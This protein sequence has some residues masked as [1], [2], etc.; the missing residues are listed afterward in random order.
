MPSDAPTCEPT[1]VEAFLGVDHSLSGRKWITREVDE[2]DIATI[3]RQ[4]DVPEALARVIAGRGIDIELAERYLNPR[5]RDEFPDPSDFADMD[6]AAGLIW[7]ALDAGRT[8]AVFADYDV[9]GATS[10]AQL[11]RWMR[12]VGHDLDLYVPDRVAEGYGPSADAFAVLKE[13][14][15]EIVITVDCGA[16]AASALTAAQEMGL[17][18]I[19]VDHHLMD[20]D[21][22]PTA[23][24]VN[25]NRDDDR[26]GCGHMAAA[27]VTFILL[28]A[29]NR[30][31]RRRGRFSDRPE[32]DL[33]ALS[34]LAA[35]GTICD[36]VALTGINR[37]IV[38]QGLKRMSGTSH[39]GLQALADVAGVDGPATPYHAG[40]LLGP[41][42]NAGGRVGRA[43]LGARLLSTEDQ[44]EATKIASQLDRFNTERRDI[45]RDVL[46]AALAQLGGQDEDRGVLIAAGEDWHP[47]VIGIA[48]GRIKDK[49]GKP[50]IVI[51]IDR[52]SQPAVGKGSG[53]SVPGVNLGAAISAAREAGLLSSGGGHAMAG[54]LTV[55]PD[56]ITELTAFLD[57]R[58]AA[59]LAQASDA[60]AM[61]LDGLLTPSS[62][63]IGLADLLSRAGPFG[64]GNAEPRFALANLRVSFAK[65]VGT[66]HVRYTL[67][68]RDGTSISGIAFRCA[69]QPIGQSL[70]AA[71]GQEWHVAGR[72]K[73]DEWQGR[74]RVQ[75]QLEDM[76]AV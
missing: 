75:L 35:L 11:I 13:R 49:F 40:F 4:Q 25:P 24:L 2:R 46:D 50:S 30:E 45:E 47:G 57:D 23:A 7:D 14:G 44:A 27:G 52:S 68:D 15:A 29:L 21:I 5:L 18:V 72:L 53:R 76:A 43:D 55:D 58:L 74:K 3:S 19:V 67:Q 31:G 66:D 64:Q 60:M 48:A 28:A 63:N 20:G 41:R 34:D 37:A 62:A 8:L 10:A 39:I 9:D 51:G 69:D 17:Q 36:V 59:E 42:I 22:P 61:R 6:K 65:R 12:S 16:A 70:L 38:T 26:S 73:A 32:P 56:R 54:G 33:L 1:R 71:D